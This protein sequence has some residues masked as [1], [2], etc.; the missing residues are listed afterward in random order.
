MTQQPETFA[1][2]LNPSGFS[3]ADCGAVVY[4][5]GENYSR[6]CEHEAAAIVADMQATVY[7]QSRFE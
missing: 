6:Q 7:G 2:A 1:E 5:D 3:C 4:F